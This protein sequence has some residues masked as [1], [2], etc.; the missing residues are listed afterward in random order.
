MNSLQKPHAG[1]AHECMAADTEFIPLA[2][3][4]GSKN[5]RRHTEI[6]MRIMPFVSVFL[7]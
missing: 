2:R 1:T 7:K 3:L 6:S 4:C 5:T